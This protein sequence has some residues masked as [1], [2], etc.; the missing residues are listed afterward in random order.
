MS[1]KNETDENDGLDFE[2][3]LGDAEHEGLDKDLLLPSRGTKKDIIGQ[4]RRCETS[5]NEEKYT[6]KRG[7]IIQWKGNMKN[8]RRPDYG[9]PMI[10]MEVLNPPIQELEKD[11]GS[12]YF[13]DILTIKAGCLDTDGDFI[14]FHYD[15]RRFEPYGE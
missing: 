8:K 10:V 12:T 15:G 7:D 11:S 14:V 13:R 9:V 6:F 1:I 3:V 2:G 4:L 5:F